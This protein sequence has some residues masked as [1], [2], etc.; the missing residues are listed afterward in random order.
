[1]SFHNENDS[2]DNKL[3]KW[4][5][6]PWILWLIQNEKLWVPKLVE[7]DWLDETREEMYGK[8]FDQG[9]VIEVRTKKD[10]TIFSD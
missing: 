6:H 4:V 2:E 7:T 8:N 5:T 9:L 1:M 3:L 10:S